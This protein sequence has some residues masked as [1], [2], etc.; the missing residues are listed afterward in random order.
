MQTK[1]KSRIGAILFGLWGILHIVGGGSILA[2][3]AESPATGFAV[4]RDSAG[5][6]PAIAGSILGY[7][8]FLIAV[9]GLAVTLVAWRLNW[10]NSAL[11]LGVNTA[12]AG[13]LDLGLVLFLLLPGYVSV[14]EASIGVSLLIAA[15]L[16]GGIACSARKEAAQSRLKVAI[17]NNG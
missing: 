17:G 7:L 10:R 12:I 2:A 11:G 6:F 14:G 13:V 16:F 4:Y 3:V 9:A 5:T 1:T 15:T 8:A